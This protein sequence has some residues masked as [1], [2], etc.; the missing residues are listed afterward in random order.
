MSK[1]RNGNGIVGMTISVE[2]TPTNLRNQ[3]RQ[4]VSNAALGFCADYFYVMKDLLFIAFERE[5][6]QRFSIKRTTSESLTVQ[7]MWMQEVRETD[8]SWGR[9]LEGCNL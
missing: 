4:A 1:L 9:G 5:T 7:I 6:C 2:E 3:M 8:G